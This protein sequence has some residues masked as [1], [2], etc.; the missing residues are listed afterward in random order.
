MKKQLL[1]LCFTLLIIC[2]SYAQWQKQNIGSQKDC[3]N[4]QFQSANLIVIAAYDGL[5]KSTDGGATWK[6]YPLADLQG[7]AIIASTIE[8]VFFLNNTVGF[9]TGSIGSAND[10]AILKTTNGGANWAIHPLSI[11]ADWPREFNDLFF[12]N[13]TTG[14]AVGTNGKIVKTTNEGNA[15]AFMPSSITADLYSIYFIDDNTGYAVGEEYILKTTNAGESW[16]SKKIPDVTFNSVHFPTP[17]TG[18]AVGDGIH[19]ECKIYKTVDG[20]VTWNELP[21]NDLYASTDVFFFN[22]DEGYSTSGNLVL[23]TLDGGKLWE[24]KRID[25]Y[26]LI[27]SLAFNTTSNG[28]L[29]GTDLV[30]LDG[31]A[32]MTTNAGGEYA[33]IA[34][35]TYKNS[36]RCD[37]YVYDFTPV[38][39]HPSNYTYKWLFNGIPF[40]TSKNA[41]Y[42]YSTPNN[43]DTVSLIVTNAYYSDTISKNIIANFD[44][45]LVAK[46]GNDTTICFGKTL[47]LSASGGVNYKWIP[48]TGLNNPNIANPITS[49]KSAITYSVIVSNDICKDTADI[50]VNV[51]DSI[52]ALPTKKLNITANTSYNIFDFTSP[53]HGFALTPNATFA[54]TKDGGDTWTVRN[55]ALS[56]VAPYGDMEFLND[57]VGFIALG[58]YYKTTNGGA[59]FQ[60]MNNRIDG[61]MREIEFPEEMIGYATTTLPS[62]ATSKIWKTI[63]GGE[64]W[65]EQIKYPGTYLNRLLCLNKDTCFC[66]GGTYSSEKPLFFRTFNGGQN[67]TNIV[68]P[69]AATNTMLY[70]IYFVNKNLGFAGRYKTTDLGTTWTTMTAAPRN[71]DIRGIRFIDEK[72]GF[73][74]SYTGELYQTDDGGDCWQITKKVT[75]V[76]D[77]AFLTQDNT[78]FLGGMVKFLGEGEVYRSRPNIITHI[79]TEQ[80]IHNDLD[81]SIYPNPLYENA[82]LQFHREIKNATL[83]LLNIMGQEVRKNSFSGSNYILEKEG[84]LPGIYFIQ[85]NAE[86]EQLLSKKIIV[87]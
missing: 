53:L 7:A 39:N 40:S 61:G 65:T 81:Y 34:S 79:D 14:Y 35:F 85:I 21:T 66:V 64:Y 77:R 24:K 57:S 4:V 9:A 31:R 59:S 12:I 47:Q 18:Y 44:K 76:L 13:Q 6:K 78:L 45:L 56:H 46:T 2:S 17:E 83:I 52:P 23:K 54:Y 38:G 71:Y 19:D 62:P 28:V 11:S 42:T 67:W 84:L 32:Y 60:Q 22:A 36:N 55:K 48:A 37:A 70:D 69:N 43:N 5:I 16:T 33:P 73:I 27:N 82:T 1:L 86:N 8:S 20:G 80:T 75:G 63:D 51:S 50:V 29:V 30:G 72:V 10:Y 26:F 15:W 58:A 25:T 41:S 68:L 74:A 87:K 49:I 3:F